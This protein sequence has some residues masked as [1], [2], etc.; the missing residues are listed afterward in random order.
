MTLIDRIRDIA[1]VIR[2]NREPE[3]RGPVDDVTGE[4]LLVVP[5]GIPLE[6]AAEHH[7]P[8]PG[9]RWAHP[10]VY[11]PVWHFE[12]PTLPATGP[13]RAQRRAAA[14]GR[15]ARAEGQQPRV[16]RQRAVSSNHRRR[17]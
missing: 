9:Y 2:D 3:W 16:E 17:R 6:Y 15:E 12:R 4:R 5:W 10:D 13:N 11:E 7:P 1:R 8:P 14:R